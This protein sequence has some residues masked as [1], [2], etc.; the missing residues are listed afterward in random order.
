MSGVNVVM[1]EGVSYR[2]PSRFLLVG[3]MNPEEGEL[4]P[5]LLDRFG[6]PPFPMS[7]AQEPAA[8]KSDG[9]PDQCSHP[10]LFEDKTA[11]DCSASLGA[12]LGNGDKEHEERDGKPVIEAC[13]HIE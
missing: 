4:R 1:R 6:H 5:Q 11:K 10:Q 2:H 9:A 13:F 12:H 3:T 8:G 7:P